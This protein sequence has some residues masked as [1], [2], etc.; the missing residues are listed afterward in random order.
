MSEIGIPLPPLIAKKCNL[1]GKPD[2]HDF[3]KTAILQLSD[4]V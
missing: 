4:A 3:N 2:A 1:I